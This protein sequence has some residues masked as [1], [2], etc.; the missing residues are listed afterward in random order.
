MKELQPIFKQK[1][2]TNSNMFIS[3][4]ITT[5]IKIKIMIK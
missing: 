3:K 4:K 2:E 5:I 1:T